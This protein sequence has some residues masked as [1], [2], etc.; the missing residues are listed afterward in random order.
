LRVVGRRPALGALRHD[1][2]QRGFK[3]GPMLGL[4]GSSEHR[5]A[6]SYPQEPR[7]VR[8]SDL[9]LGR[10][11]PKRLNGLLDTYGNRSH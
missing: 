6:S 11:T 3:A 7:F 10:L 5:N 4:A 2:A 9:S 8:L 1:I